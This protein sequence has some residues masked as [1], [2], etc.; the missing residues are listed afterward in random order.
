[1]TERARKMRAQYQMQAQSLKQRIEMRINRVPKKLWKMTMGDLLAQTEGADVVE[2][3]TAR[4]LVGDVKRLRFVL[5]AT[6]IH[7]K[8]LTPT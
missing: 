1:M 6:K 2:A 5:S 4:K 8:S 3:A 7:V